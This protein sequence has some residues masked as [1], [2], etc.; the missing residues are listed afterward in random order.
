MWTTLG[1]IIMSATGIYASEDFRV[2]AW[3]KKIGR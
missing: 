1:D 3:P 2:Y